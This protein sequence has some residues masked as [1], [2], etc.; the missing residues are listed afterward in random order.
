[1]QPEQLQSGVWSLAFELRRRKMPVFDIRFIGF[2]MKEIR[3][4]RRKDERCSVA[5]AGGV[6]GFRVP[7]CLQLG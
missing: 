2:F 7:G 1:M 6:S 3:P 4:Q 5:V